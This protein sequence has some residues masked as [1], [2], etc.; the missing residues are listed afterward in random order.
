VAAVKFGLFVPQGWILDL[1][2]IED[3][4]EQ[5][6]AMVRVTKAA[7]R[8]GFDSAWLYD[9][10]HTYHRPVLE[11]TFECW[12]SMAALA[13]ETSR[14]RLGQMVTCNSYRNPA[15]LAKEATT[16][17][18]MSNGRLDFGIGAGWYEHEYLAYG[19]EFPP[20]GDRLRMMG[21]ALAICRAMWTEPY[22]SFEGEHY[23]ISGAINEPKPVQKPHPPIWIGG[24]GE[25]VTLKL[26]AQYADATN[27]GSG[28]D[29]DYYER[30]LEVLA[31]HCDAIGRDPAT[32]IH[33][34][35]VETTV[36]GPGQDPI[37]LTERYR[38]GESV[39]E[40]RT[41]AIVGGKQEIIDAYARLID[42]GMDYIIIADVPGLATTDVVEF[43]GEEI[44]PAFR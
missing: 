12:T 9:H 39:E 17:D 40:Y 21:E 13:R 24:E 3:Q 1:V 11:T 5:F 37:D 23:R 8:L 28:W 43:L 32:I 6:E 44:L 29:M 2:D 4:V 7:E 15:L 35:D 41:H 38:R 26:A 19:Y 20:V 18:V 10:F 36:V 25:K 31:A 16:V 14:I 33:S 22:A 30:K 34:T 27:F 42:A